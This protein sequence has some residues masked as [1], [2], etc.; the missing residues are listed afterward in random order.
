LNSSVLLCQVI[1]G[2]VKKESISNPKL[3]KEEII[4]QSFD[5]VVGIPGKDLNY[6]EIVI[7]D[8]DAVIPKYLIIY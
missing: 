8:E 6:D 3:S 1:H 5:S 7:Y 2:K 4:N